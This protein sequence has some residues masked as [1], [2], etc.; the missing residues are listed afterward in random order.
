MWEILVYILL[1]ISVDIFA[2]IRVKASGKPGHGSMFIENNAGEK[3]VIY[4]IIKYSFQLQCLITI[5]FSLVLV[6]RS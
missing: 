1:Y 3:L 4:N 5:T 2:G 6:Y